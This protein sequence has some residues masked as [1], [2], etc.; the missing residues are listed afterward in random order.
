MCAMAEMTS[1]NGAVMGFSS[2]HSYTVCDETV[3]ISAGSDVIV[4]ANNVSTLWQLT[5]G[6]YNL[7]HIISNN[8]GVLCVSE[9][10]LSVRLFFYDVH[11]KQLIQTVEDIAISE[12]QHMCFSNDGRTLF[13][14]CTVN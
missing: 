11:N 13:V 5:D 4:I 1:F 8:Q 10:R 9:K 7:H 6:K 2:P 12:V 14:L 3:L